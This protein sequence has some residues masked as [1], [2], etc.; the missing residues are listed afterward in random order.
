MAK[1]KALFEHSIL[2]N[3]IE[4][5]FNNFFD[6]HGNS[7]LRKHMKKF[8]KCGDNSWGSMAK[9]DKFNFSRS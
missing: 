9:M 6:S 4:V 8:G 2:P 7:D 3:M 5:S 1:S